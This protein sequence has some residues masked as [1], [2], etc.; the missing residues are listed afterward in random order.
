MP[1][2]GRLQRINPLPTRTD[3]IRADGV[4]DWL[5]PRLASARLSTPRRNAARDTHHRRQADSLDNKL[6]PLGRKYPLSWGLNAEAPN[7]ICTAIS[8]EKT[9]V[10]W[11][12]LSE[13]H[14]AGKLQRRA[15]PQDLAGQLAR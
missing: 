5:M 13:I 15:R 1:R 9:A 2:Y 6:P 12:A 4:G 8:G 14:R 10:R 7:A 3:S 11:E